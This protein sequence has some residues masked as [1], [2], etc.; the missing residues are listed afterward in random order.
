MG[1]ARAQ[2]ILRPV[3]DKSFG[4]VGRLMRPTKTAR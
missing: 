2:P 1:F 4:G 3:I